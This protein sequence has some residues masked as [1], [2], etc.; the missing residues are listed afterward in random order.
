LKDLDG[1][2]CREQ[3]RECDAVRYLLLMAASSSSAR[4]QPGTTYSAADIRPLIGTFME[5][6]AQDRQ[7]GGRRG[8][9]DLYALRAEKAP[10]RIEIVPT[11]HRSADEESSRWCGR[12]VQVCAR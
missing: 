5:S 1:Q 3:H 12:Y 9:R 4:F 10:T 7:D 11:P 2:K 6:S 8:G